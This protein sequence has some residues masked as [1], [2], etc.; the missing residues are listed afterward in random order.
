MLEILGDYELEMP[1]ILDW[2]IPVDTARTVNMDARTLTDI[3]LH[4][5]QV[6]T[7]K[8]YTPMIYFNWYQSNHYYYL[9]EL[10]QTDKVK[11]RQS[12]PGRAFNRHLKALYS[13]NTRRIY[14][15]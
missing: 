1:I 4:F 2:E 15:R 8:G 7:E 10:E 11:F 5:C 14:L 13:N 6:M 9:K 12:V 3:Q